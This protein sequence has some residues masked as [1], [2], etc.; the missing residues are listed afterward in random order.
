MECIHCERDIKDIKPN[1]VIVCSHCY[2]LLIGQIT[3][4]L[5]SN[6]ND[7]LLLKHNMNNVCNN[8]CN[9]PCS[10]QLSKTNEENTIKMMDCNQYSI[11][12]VRKIP[13]FTIVSKL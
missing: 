4:I 10:V 2:S 5:Q 6:S 12:I 9:C 3:P 8:M 7:E 13:P 11:K 1:P